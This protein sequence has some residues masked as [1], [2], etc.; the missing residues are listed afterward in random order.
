MYNIHKRFLSYIHVCSYKFIIFMNKVSPS[1]DWVDILPNTLLSVL[2]TITARLKRIQIVPLED[3]W[4][5]FPKYSS[6]PGCNHAQGRIGAR[7]YIYCI[8]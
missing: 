4:L 7:K 3:L 2:L 1:Y 5:R 8:K 6:F